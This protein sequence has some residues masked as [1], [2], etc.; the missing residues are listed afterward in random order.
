LTLSGNGQRLRLAFTTDTYVVSPLFFPGG[1]IGRLSI[2]GTVN[3]LATSGAKPTYLS[4]AF[5]LEEGL[6]ISDLQR[7]V[8]SMRCA[9]E[10][11]G[12][13]II[14]GDTK[15]VPKGAADK[16][17]INTAGIGIIPEGTCVSGSNCRPGDAI[18]LSGTLGDHGLAV[19]S[20][21]EG[22]SFQ[23]P[24]E[25][26]CAPLNQLVTAVLNACPDTHAL[27]DPTRG[28]L[29]TTLN[30]L[31]HQSGV[32][33]VIQETALP[34]TDAVRGAC[35]MLGFDPLY[36]ANEGKM[37]VIMPSD[38]ADR[39]VDAMHRSPYGKNAA[40]IGRVRTEHPGR[41]V[42]HTNLG[43]NRIVDMLSGELLPRI[44]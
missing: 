38:Q 3:D 43:T 37:V 35:E 10:E 14:T 23:S 42:L 18:I 5:V 11:A 34:I 27:R 30:E 6:A 1:D 25:S 44:C 40:I 2:C 8:E 12:V 19:L 20:Q 29:A 31:A 36:V 22:L 26:D 9:A 24:I 39:V 41:V 17:F 16:M 28:G 21:R 4:V 32:G 7:V 15:V 33:M 13:L